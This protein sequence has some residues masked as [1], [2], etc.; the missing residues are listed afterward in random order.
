M[1]FLIDVTH[2]AHVHFFRPLVGRLRRE[3]HEVLLTARDKD[4]T[5]ELC[6][7]FGL[8]PIRQGPAGT[9]ALGL[10]RELLAR[11]RALFGLLRKV[12][13]DAALAIAGTFLSLPGRLAG[14]PTYVFYDTEHAT[15]SNLLA[16]PFATC[17]YVPRCYFKTIRWRHERYDGYHELAYLHPRYFRPDPAVLPEAGLSPGESFAIVRFVGWGAGHDLGKRGLSDA[18]KR[19]ALAALAAQ[20]RVLISS[21]GPLPPDLEPQR[22]ALDAHRLHHLMAYA[23][24]VFGESGTMPSEAALLGVPSVY[25]NPLRL[26]YLE[27]LE[28]RYGIVS[29]YSP[30]RLAQ[31]L[32]RAVSLLR[33]GDPEHWRAV[34][35]RIVAEKID[36]SEM[37]HRICMERPYARRRSAHA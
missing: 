31:A 2:P 5:L 4:V 33:Q 6:A 17:V 11:Q 32:D 28:A 22:L 1:R 24:L 37:L 16:Y 25:L 19:E 9:G 10:M 18:Q 26:G 14:V 13:P 7:E 8:E 36:V 23:S 15:A 34:A 21:E 12:R 27:E 29:T 35:R 30:E 20:T 3:G